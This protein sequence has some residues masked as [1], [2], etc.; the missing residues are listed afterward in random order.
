MNNN[1]IGLGQNPNPNVPD[2][3]IGFGMA[4]FQDTQAR[5]TFENLTDAQKTQVIRRIETGNATGED[6]KQKISQT[7]ESLRN[8]TF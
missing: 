5:Q 4:L 8:G 3:P 2:L 1:F 6:A 7:I